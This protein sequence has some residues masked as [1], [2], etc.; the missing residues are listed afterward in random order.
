MKMKLG[1]MGIGLIAGLA[2][3]LAAWSYVTANQPVSG[4][5]IDPP[6]RA[7]DFTLTTGSGSQFNLGQQRG[8]VTLMFFG[9]TNC[10]DVCPVTL[11]DYRRIRQALGDLADQVNL[12]FITIDPER[13]SLE[14]VA[15]YTAN[16]DPAIVG[17]SGTEAELEPV[18]KAYGVYREKVETASAAGYLMDHSSRVY[19]ID[20]QGQLRLTFPFGLELEKMVGDIRRL[21]RNK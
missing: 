18:W 1:F 20:R 9:Y 19:V 16:F 17:L 5:L 12:V 21:L 7:A 3:V 4:V 2:L 14:R 11:S 6:A 13:D 10:P 8:K 15:A